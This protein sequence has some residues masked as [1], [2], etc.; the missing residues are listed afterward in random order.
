MRSM[1]ATDAEWKKIKDYSHRLKKGEI[2]VSKQEASVFL[3]ALAAQET[4]W[5]AE[6]LREV[7]E[8]IEG[9]H[10]AN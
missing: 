2:T 1:K 9:N 3:H 6:K 5:I 4:P 8:M 7:A 10:P